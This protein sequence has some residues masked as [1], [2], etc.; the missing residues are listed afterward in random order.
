MVSEHAILML[1]LLLAVA[2]VVLAV[3]LMLYAGKLE[4]RLKGIDELLEESGA[5]SRQDGLAR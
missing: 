3:A 2:V 4:K 1:I 5:T